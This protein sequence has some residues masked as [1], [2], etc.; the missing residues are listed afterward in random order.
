MS[1]QP[2]DKAPDFKLKNE[3]GND[4]ALSQFSGKKLVIYFY[5]KDDTPGCTRES[6]GF[7]EQ[8]EAF[9]EKGAQILG[10]SKDSVES[11][12]KFCKK[13]DLKIELASDSKGT[14][15]EEYGVWQEK[16][17]YGKTY[18]G[19]V[20]TT[21]LLNEAGVVEKIWKNVKVEGHVDKVLQYVT[22]G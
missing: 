20:R 9:V 18:F 8:K 16:K 12:Q 14:M 17:N 2:G 21:V 6:I 22:E 15:V 10:V 3:A 1:I 4:V 11:H 13:Y 19:I 5:P 7:S